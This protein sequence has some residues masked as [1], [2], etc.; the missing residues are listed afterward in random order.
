MKVV[1]L[2][3]GGMLG[4]KI[5]QTLIP[6]FPETIATIRGTVSEPPFCRI[7]LFQEESVIE[8]VDAM[9]FGR[10]E[11]LLREMRP[12]VVI[13][14]VGVIKQRAAAKAAI[15]SIAINAL[16]PHRLAEAC[17]TWGGRL[18]HFSTDCVFSGRRGGYT[19]EDPSDAEDLYGKS[20]CLGEVSTEN[21]LTLR[22]SI[23]G[24]EL[25]HFQSLLEWFLS[26][27]GGTVGGYTRA[28]YSGL[29]TNYLAELVG[30]L[31]V[32]HP[33]LS[34]L[35]QVASASLSKFDLLILLRNAYSLDMEIVPSDAEICDRSL[36]GQK[37]QRATGYCT[38]SWPELVRQMA[39]DPTPYDHWRDS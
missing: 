1:I 29:T 24:R 37:F 11:R 35:Y 23:I 18:I 12:Q 34:G 38:P 8:G 2:G 3:A 14:C 5:F 36:S 31:L 25:S 28:I 13:N 26:R 39:E 16:L 27:P 32:D 20:K 7:P 17:G 15:P 33:G 4:H 21:A 22:T 9:D 6:I 10:L 30:K 19:E